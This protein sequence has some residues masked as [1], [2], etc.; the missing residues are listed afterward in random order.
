MEQSSSREANRFSVS[1]EIIRILRNPKVHFLIHKCPPPVPILSQLDPVHTPTFHFLKIHLIS[2]QFPGCCCKWTCPIQAH[3]IPSTI[4]HVPLSLFRSYQIISPGPR[5]SVW[6]FRNKIQFYSEELSAPRPTSKV[7]DYTLLADR[8][9][10]FSIFAATLHIGVR[11]S[12]RS[13]RTR[14]AT[15]TATHWSRNCISLE[16]LINWCNTS[17]SDMIYSPVCSIFR[18]LNFFYF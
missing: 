1:Q 10:L 13:L 14:H 15:V 5:L 3:S 7:E 17:L 2:S 9:C 4:S 16:D 18:I 11:S 12:I 6:T 8:D